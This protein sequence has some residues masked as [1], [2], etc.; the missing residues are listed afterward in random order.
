MVTKDIMLGHIISS[1]RIKVDKVK[2]ELIAKFHTPKN[3]K[4]IQSF[5]G[6]AGFIGSL[7]KILVTSPNRC[8]IFFLRMHILNGTLGARKPLLDLSICSLP[9][10]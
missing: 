8:A 9:R 1:K 4:D 2:I 6:Y 10:R 7:S 5:M 3:L